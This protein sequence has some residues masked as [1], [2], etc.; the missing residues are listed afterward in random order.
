MKVILALAVA[1]FAMVAPAQA[2]PRMVCLSRGA[3]LDLLRETYA[4]SAAGTG[5]IGDTFIVELFVSPNRAWA[6]VMTGVPEQKSC[7][8]LAGHGWL[9]L[10]DVAG[11]R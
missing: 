1:V 11:T 4:A 6:M 10:D 2:E 7:I 5:I 8:A 3:M 9:A